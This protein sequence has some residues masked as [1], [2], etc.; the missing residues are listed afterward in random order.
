M[1]VV[2]CIFDAQVMGAPANHM[3]QPDRDLDIIGSM[4]HQLGA[5]CQQNR[6]PPNNQSANLCWGVSSNPCPEWP[7]DSGLC[8]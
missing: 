6:H 1:A 2:V 4:W 5:N 8:V 7:G 3:I